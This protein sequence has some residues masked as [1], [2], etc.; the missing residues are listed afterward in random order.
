MLTRKH[1]KNISNYFTVVEHV[2]KAFDTIIDSDSEAVFGV[3]AQLSPGVMSVVLVTPPYIRLGLEV[4]DTSIVDDEDTLTCYEGYLVEPYFLPLYGALNGELLN[5]LEKM[6][7][8][9]GEIVEM[10]WLFRK[11]IDEGWKDKAIDMY[12]S[13]LEGNEF[14]MESRL[15]RQLQN[16][17]LR[18]LNTISA[19]DTNKPYIEEAEKKI[20]GTGVQFQLRVL[21]SSDKPQ[22]LRDRLEDILRKYDSHNALRL[23][24]QQHKR[25]KAM[26]RDRILTYDTQSQILS[27][28]EMA[29]M[30]GGKSELIV[31]PEVVVAPPVE[32]VAVPVAEKVVEVKKKVSVND[33]I[34]LLPYYPRK[35]VQAD[36]NIVTRLAD[37]M[38]RV[39]LIKTAR[40]FNESVIAGVRLTVVQCDI[41]RGKTLTNVIN[42]AKDIQA[43]LGEESLGVE[44][45]DA[46]DTV[47]F[48][49]PNKQP[50][51]I[52]LRE[53]IELPRFHAFAKENPLA[54]IV[55]VDEVN[56]PIYLSLAKLVHLMVAGTT[57]S[58]KSVFV[59]SLIVS[60][61][62][63]NT[64]DMLRMYMI[65]PK[66]VE[67]QQYKG[68]PHVESVVTDM[69][70]AAE[71]LEQLAEE[72]DNRYKQFE[73]VGVKT[74]SMYNQKAKDK[75]PY[76]VCVIDEYADLKDT[77]PEVE[78]YIVRL[79]Q[80]A[81]AAGIHLVLAT[82]RPSA[83]I[84]SSK[85]KANVQ[86]VISFNLGNNTN[87]KT[88]FGT[89]IPFSLLGAG[90]GVM[91]ILGYPK[92]FQRFQS[93]IICPKEAE[94]EAVFDSLRDYYTG[95]QV[96]P[97]FSEAPVEQPQEEPEESTLQDVDDL[98][99]SLK[100][101]IA[102]TGETKVEPLRKQLG[103]KA[104]TMTD[105]MQQLV[106][107]GWLI[108]HKSNV[109]GFE[110][111]APEE[112]LAKY[113]DTIEK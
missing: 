43:A 6:E 66:R 87:Y 78:D 88:C 73:V 31:V 109:K 94:E 28:Q 37:A 89:G 26:Y 71:V 12:E 54:F 49:I 61:L 105:L 107:E 92:P 3:E 96:K 74:I 20:L 41:P 46:A 70:E 14:P 8:A 44:Q 68:F 2:G 47:K 98:L 86:N 67:L 64:P 56:N 35:E 102:T 111:V 22:E 11:R 5:D 72:M 34:S 42:K 59:N 91:K 17:V 51:I 36:P 38:K 32:K 13:F 76:V 19:F 99:N 69:E 100:K 30:F 18:L 81:R 82:Q 29:S 104:Q 108:K 48:A 40:L 112:E 53:L 62:A 7:I 58:G 60:L 15:G 63:Y 106:D 77:H 1:H 113:K 79:G 90:D 55:G 16:K 33:M 95:Y 57:G 23:C 4:P 65:D 83:N 25:F 9:D 110:V 39:G 80:L 84:V 21:V 103:V 75:M 85:I 24:R 93:P 97:L 10:Q 27:R 52:C 50:A 101:I 45:G